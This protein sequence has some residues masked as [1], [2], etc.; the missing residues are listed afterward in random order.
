M[1]P[2]LKKSSRLLA[3][4]GKLEATYEEF[5]IF[6]RL[7]HKNLLFPFVDE[8]FH[9]NCQ[10]TFKAMKACHYSTLLKIKDTKLLSLLQ[11]MFIFLWKSRLNSK[12]LDYTRNFLNLAPFLTD[13]PIL[14][15]SFLFVFMLGCD[16]LI[17]QKGRQNQKISGVV[18]FQN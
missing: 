5:I 3:N 12:R 9:V 15:F 11:Q 17:S 8:T 1:I 2:L 10:G 14:M 13:Q 4:I 6:W 16:W 7:K 18:K